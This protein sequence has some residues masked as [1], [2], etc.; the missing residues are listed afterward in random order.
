MENRESNRLRLSKV[1]QA[2]VHLCSDSVLCLGRHAMCDATR[3]MFMRWANHRLYGEMKTFEVLR[4]RVPRQSEGEL[5]AIAGG[6][7]TTLFIDR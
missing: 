2:K 4:L 6:V 1:H 3:N 7:E 5:D